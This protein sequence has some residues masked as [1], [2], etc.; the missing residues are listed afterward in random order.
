MDVI[1]YVLAADA[2]IDDDVLTVDFVG[3]VVV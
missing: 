1:L 3:T 2:F